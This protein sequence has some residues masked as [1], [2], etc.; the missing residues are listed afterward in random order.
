MKKKT[1]IIVF[2]ILLIATA[3]FAAVSDTSDG[4][5]TG[6]SGIK[7]GTNISAVKNL[8]RLDTDLGEI[9][10][11][12]RDTDKQAFGFTVIHNDYV[13]Y[14]GSLE[15]V[16]LC[17]KDNNKTTFI[18]ISDDLVK[19]FGQP[20]T[21]HDVWHEKGKVWNSKDLRII[22]DYRTLSTGEE[23]CYV[24]YSYKPL[25]AIERKEHPMHIKKE[26]K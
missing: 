8:L 17:F 15:S 16:Q 20:T 3:A 4:I 10:F 21:L 9:K 6:F 25:L 2:A 19:K 18:K 22:L 13:F 12:S 7:W 23:M 14:H 5:Y 11:Y 24:T 26:G 1:S